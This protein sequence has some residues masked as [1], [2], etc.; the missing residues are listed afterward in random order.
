MKNT[1]VSDI[2]TR[3]WIKTTPNTNLLECSKKMVR[4]RVNSLVLTNRKQIKGFISTKDILWALVKKGSKEDL[5]TIKAKDISPKKII[6]IK[7]TATVDEAISKMRKFKFQRIP[8][9]DNGEVK[10]IITVI[11]IMRFYPESKSEL[12]ELELIREEEEKL[13]RLENSK[14]ETIRDGICEECGARGELYRIN[15]ILMCSSCA[16]SF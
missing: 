16:D 2:M 1:L 8:V 13:K 4:K 5:S 14:E 9:V 12:E 10:G 15:G 7:P 11:D 6:T 3:N